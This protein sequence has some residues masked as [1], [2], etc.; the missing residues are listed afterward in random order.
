MAGS[1]SDAY[2][3]DVLKA[4]TGQATTILA[5][6]PITPYIALF[7]VAPTDST[8]G[9]EVSGGSYARTS[10]AGKWATPAA[11]SVATNATVTFPT[12]SGSWGTVVAF[13][14]MDA[15]SAGNLLMWGDLTA[16]KAVGSGDIAEFASGQ[17]TLTED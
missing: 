11:G 12:A 16:S 8:A 14:V 17:L 10:S 2:E 1:K 13:G 7:T 3:I 4:V 9:T 15:S 5:T 6:T